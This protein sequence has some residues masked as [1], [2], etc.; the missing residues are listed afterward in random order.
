[1]NNKRD[2]DKM[3]TMLIYCLRAGNGLK[4]Y[5]AAQAYDARHEFW[6]LGRTA[7]HLFILGISALPFAYKSNLAC[8]TIIKATLTNSVTIHD[9]LSLVFR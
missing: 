3:K 9:C 1:M 8:L 4:R 7:F 2:H 6:D 5:P